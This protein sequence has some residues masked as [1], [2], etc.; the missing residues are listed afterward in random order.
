MHTNKRFVWAG[1]IVLAVCILVFI[2][3]VASSPFSWTAERH[4]AGTLSF[5]FLGASLLFA[6][7][8]KTLDEKI[9][10]CFL[11]WFVVSAWLRGDLWLEENFQ[12]LC[13]Y[14]CVFGV[15]LPAARLLGK[16]AQ[17]PTALAAVVLPAAL[18]AIAVLASLTVDAV[19][20]PY[21]RTA[22]GVTGEN[23]LRMQVG[24]H[25]NSAAAMF[26]VALLLTLWLTA[27]L[28]C[29][30]V[31]LITVPAVMGLY[32]AIALT[33]SRTIML[34]TAFAFA[35]IAAVL[36]HDHLP[37]KGWKKITLAGVGAVVVLAAAYKGFDLASQ[38]ASWLKI[39][40]ARAETVV[41]AR[42]LLRDLFTMTGRTNIF[43]WIFD[44]IANEP[45]IL[46][47]GATSEQLSAALTWAFHTHN[48]Y[49]QCLV[50]CGIPGV[51]MAVW[52]SLRALWAAWRVLPGKYALADKMMAIIPLAMLPNAISEIC[53]FA[54]GMT[55][56]NTVFFF[57]LGYAVMAAQK[58]GSNQKEP[59]NA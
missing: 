37:L 48:A 51:L 26:L 3:S 19:Y 8:G 41:E 17:L 53:L 16:K 7:L 14:A 5:A 38:L 55:L 32:M 47:Y 52:F 23:G 50:M 20:V 13:G 25:P 27:R 42:P 15:A 43:G 21:I 31:R 29:R 10:L 18:A 40:A 39:Q 45:R 11:G 44:M 9:G 58:N 57:C 30:W 36:L 56:Y 34:Q 59:S 46:L 12:A 4:Y 1:I 33:V 35:V 49:L 6:G 54:D 2:T 28:R 22:A 24:S